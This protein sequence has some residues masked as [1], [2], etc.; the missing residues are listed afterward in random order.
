MR[1]LLHERLECQCADADVFAR[2]DRW[3]VPT[4]DQL[5]D[6]LLG[7]RQELRDLWNREQAIEF[8][9]ERSLRRGAGQQHGLKVSGQP[10]GS[11][12]TVHESSDRQRGGER[13]VGLERIQA[14]VRD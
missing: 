4:P 7:E 9:S 1:I 8:R 6:V 3:K 5:V 12:R 2:A 11:S 10:C 14:R 13:H